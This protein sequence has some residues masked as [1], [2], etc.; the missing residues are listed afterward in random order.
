MLMQQLIWQHCRRAIPKHSAKIK[1]A[2]NSNA[3]TQGENHFKNIFSKSFISI[4]LISYIQTQIFNN[5]NRIFTTFILVPEKKVL[6]SKSY[7]Q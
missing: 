3:S 1:K 4:I 5:F 6:I 2:A 7:V